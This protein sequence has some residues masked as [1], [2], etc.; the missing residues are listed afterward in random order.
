[1]VFGIRHLAVEITFH[2][3]WKNSSL[4]RR[5]G[6]LGLFAILVRLSLVRLSLTAVSPVSVHL[7]QRN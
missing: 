7:A 5:C 3:E 4:G 1:M 6:H 2:A